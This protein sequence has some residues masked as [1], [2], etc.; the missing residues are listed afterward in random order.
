MGIDKPGVNNESYNNWG[1]TRF[2][3]QIQSKPK[4]MK[5]II[6]LL[7]QTASL[8]SY[9]FKSTFR[10]LCT[11]SYTIAADFVCDI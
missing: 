6:D 5:S 3:N 11:S 2:Q 1:L 7:V 10:L 9:P 4:Y 8:K